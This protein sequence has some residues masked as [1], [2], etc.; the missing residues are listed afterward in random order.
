[1][2][3]IGFQLSISWAL[4]LLT[5]L[6]TQVTA[7]VYS[8][9]YQVLTASLLSMSLNEVI[10]EQRRIW[11]EFP[12]CPHIHH[13]S[14]ASQHAFYCVHFSFDFWTSAPSSGLGPLPSSSSSM[15]R[16]LKPNYT[17]VGRQRGFLSSPPQGPGGVNEYGLTS[18]GKALRIAP[19]KQ[20]FINFYVSG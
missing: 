15:F 14:S 13:S 19:K 4:T 20:Q 5:S 16:G 9:L 10:T 6:F 12:L 1:M 2:Q 3:S 18:K 7:H 8:G 11:L 17:L